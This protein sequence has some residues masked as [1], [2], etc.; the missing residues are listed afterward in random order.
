MLLPEEANIV[1]GEWE[2]GSVP[3]EL[4]GEKYNLVFPIEEIVVHENYDVKKGVSSG[5]DI[6]VF[7]VNATQLNN[8]ES[9]LIYPACLPKPN[10]KIPKFGIQ[11]S[12]NPPP[13]YYYVEKFF[14]FSIQRYGDLFKQ[15]HYKMEIIDRCEDPKHVQV[16]GEMLKYPSNTSYP[17]ATVCAKE[18]TRHCYATGS[19]GSPLMIRDEQKSSRFSIEG[20]Q[21]FSKGCDLNKLSFDNYLKN[22]SFFSINQENPSVFTKIFCYLPWIAKQFKLS[23]EYENEVLGD[24]SCAV[25]TGDP[26]D[27]LKQVCRE[28]IGYFNS[29]ERPCIFP[30]YYEGQLQDKC[31][32]F[33]ANADWI[34]PI[35][36]CPTWNITA[37]INGTNSYKFNDLVGT[38]LCP[39]ED[40]D[41]DPLIKTCLIKERIPPFVPCKNNCPGGK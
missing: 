4:S 24:K 18:L 14:P 22:T 9:M 32:L 11:K 36:R 5:Y 13:Q 8:T 20:I 35:F 31:F 38:E 2:L 21:S 37:K 25:G 19:S 10:R 1:C 40:G 16:F 15:Y 39:N 30:F 6:A 27:G 28:S 17:A 7:R 12:W 41:L 29:E 34:I 26:D 33:T 3:K 23:Y